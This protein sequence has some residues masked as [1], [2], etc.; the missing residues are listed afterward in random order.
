MSPLPGP[1]SLALIYARGP[2]PDWAPAS[3]PVGWAAAEKE[4]RREGS[5]RIYG[6]GGGS[7]DPL[8]ARTRTAILRGPVVDE[9]KRDA[10]VLALEQG[11][12]RLQVVPALARYA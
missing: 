3:L 8:S 12:D 7:G 11:D 9:L 5:E 4:V 1:S 10:E 6:A 2:R